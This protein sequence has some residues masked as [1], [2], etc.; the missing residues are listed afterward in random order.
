MGNAMLNLFNAWGQA[1]EEAKSLITL[2]SSEDDAMLA[3][4]EEDKI[5]LLA[6]SVDEN[7][8]VTPAFLPKNLFGQ[9]YGDFG[10]YKVCGA[11]GEEMPYLLAHNVPLQEVW[12]IRVLENKAWAVVGIIY[13][14]I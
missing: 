14:A 2:S 6:F 3:A 10:F 11:S 12:V 1:E 7:G 9:N 8:G 5:N 4:L 13:Y